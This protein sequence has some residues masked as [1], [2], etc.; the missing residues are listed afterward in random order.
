VNASDNARFFNRALLD[1]QVERL[2]A[3]FRHWVSSRFK[4]VG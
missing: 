2:D 4:G 3:L 1:W